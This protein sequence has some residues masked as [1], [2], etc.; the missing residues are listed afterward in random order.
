MAAGADIFW[1]LLPDVRVEERSRFLF[2]AALSAI[3]TL[4][5]TLGLAGTEALFLAEFGAGAL[6][7]TFIAASLFTVLGSMVYALR[8]GSARNDRLFTQ[9]LVG[10]GLVLSVAMVGLLEG[11]AWL[12]PPLVWFWYLAQAVF[13][14]HFWTFSSDF[15]DTQ[16]SKRLVPYFTV[17]ASVGGMLGGVLAAGMT[18]F[19][20]ATSLIAGWGGA[21]LAGAA[22]LWLARRS[23]RRWGPLELEEADETSVENLRGAL[24]YLRTSSLARWLVLAALGMVLALFLAQ[25]L[26]LD[27]FARRFPDPA[28]L[29]FFLAVYF[30][31]TNLIEIY[32]EMKVTPLLIR[33]LGVPRANLIH[34]GLMLASFAGL[35][36]N[37]G[38]VGGIA[39]RMA[40]ELMENA[41]AAPVRSLVY[42]AMPS[43]FR[44]RTR[45]FVETIVV[46]AGMAAAGLVLVTL[47][48]PAPIWLCAAGALASLFYL[49]A[50]FR[51]RRAYLDTLNEQIIKGSIDIAGVSGDIGSWEAERLAT[52]W[53][54]LLRAEGRR[55]SA[56]LLQL[57]PILADRGIV[58]PLV[59]AASH[60]N[61]DLRRSS[62]TELARVGGSSI[63]GPLALAMD[64]P[65]AS[66]RL[67]ALRGLTRPGADT[68][69]VTDRLAELLED[70][71]P[72]VRAEAAC[73]AGE[74]GFE[75]LAKMIA[76]PNAQEA[77][78]ALGVASEPLLDR[79]LER[80][81][82]SDAPVRAAA[83]ACAA[84]LATEPPIGLEQLLEF[85]QDP[86]EGVR[87]GAVQLGAGFDDDTA[88]AAI[89][90][91]LDD[92][93]PEVQAT[94]EMALGGLGADG[95]NA[96]SGI[97]R[98]QRERAVAAAL[99]VVAASGTP[100][101]RDHLCSEMRQHVHTMWYFLIGYQRL[102]T[103]PDTTV[104]FIRTA[105]RDAMQRER[106]LA[107]RT[108]D[109]LENPSIVRKVEREL[110]IGTRR[111]RDNALEMLSHMGDREAAR[112]LVLFYESG[113]FAERV[114]IASR[115]VAV[116]EDVGALLQE[117][118]GSE[119]HWIR[120]GAMACAPLDGEPP[121]EEDK[122]ER[123]LALKQ[124]PLFENMSLEQ[125]DA[126]LQ[127]TQEQDYLDGEIMC[128]EGERGDSLFLLLEGAVDIV[129][130]HGTPGAVRLNRLDAIDYFGEMAAL[131]DAPRA[132]TAVAAGPCSLLTLDGAA[133]KEL[134]L[135]MPEISFEIFR[136][137]TTRLK[138]AEE[139]VTRS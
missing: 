127:S 60:P 3:I 101:A 38:M 106:R 32:I 110:R 33:K 29:A 52:L 114:Q 135:Q 84:R 59:R 117:A 133:L 109:A 51:A 30:A 63:A 119:L 57:I 70:L 86:D 112:L 62:V 79:A 48:A 13:L 44:G 100:D 107:F 123:L 31:V 131:V 120:L 90:A 20:G 39:S 37:F 10:S 40:R 11:H 95:V 129:K 27:I 66:V 9:M 88:L 104:L 82:G 137:L 73:H 41:L 124:V 121:P 64:D 72:R 49:Y 97:L 103:S 61:A 92:P 17:G 94:A 75:I 115:V 21:L 93:S 134:I 96:V 139:R 26:Y 91:R 78:P 113:S 56:G 14:N 130:S 42:N 55:P 23:L 28:D 67:A 83:L 76:S 102:P 4:A 8:V 15:F 85:L 71:D 46:Y 128:R 105:F 24:R 45:A 125:L 50:G 81:R 7:R 6:P 98:S 138:A 69:F 2:F 12:M 58:D 19:A 89:A 87:R 68:T 122:M 126:L 136:V 74:A 108:L 1:K 99:R 65:D 18:R 25:F 54:Q 77:I 43:R 36:L 34:P 53:E 35:A 22:M 118:R 80:L 47:Q 116:P 111:S 132:A 16:A 5:Q